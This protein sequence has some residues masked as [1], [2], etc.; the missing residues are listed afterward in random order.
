MNLNYAPIAIK[1][2][3]TTDEYMERLLGMLR[4]Q[5]N[6]ERVITTLKPGSAE[7]IWIHTSAKPVAL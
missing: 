3:A 5:V 1:L 4:Q 7:V 6:P 2:I